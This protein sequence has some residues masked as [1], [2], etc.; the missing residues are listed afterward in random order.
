MQVGVSVNVA[1]LC[2]DRRDCKASE[3]KDRNI[4]A[5]NIKQKQAPPTVVP[6]S[7]RLAQLCWEGHPSAELLISEKLDL[8]ESAS[9]RAVH[10]CCIFEQNSGA[11]IT[12]SVPAVILSASKCCREKYPSAEL[13]IPAKL[14]LA[15][16][17]SIR[18]FAKAYRA[19]HLSC[20][21]L[22]NNAGAT[23]LKGF[24]TSEGVFG[25]PQVGL[26]CS[27]QAALQPCVKSH[28]LCAGW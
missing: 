16:P 12:P 20:H 17:A 18:A 5:A 28:S 1:H 19:Q 9:I 27:A 4:Q 3:M 25:L 10:A 2:T 13:L 7:L 24:F 8:A 14:D 6:M 15:E 23:N 26:P 21:I 11:S 22:I